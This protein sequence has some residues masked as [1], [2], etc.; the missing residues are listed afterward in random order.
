MTLK[1]PDLAFSEVSVFF[2]LEYPYPILFLLS[3]LMILECP[4]TL[5]LDNQSTKSPI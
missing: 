1:Q 4:L 3:L 5:V 2:Q